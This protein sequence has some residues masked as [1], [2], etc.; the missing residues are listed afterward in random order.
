MASPH[1]NSAWNGDKQ[2]LS[3]GGSRDAKAPSHRIYPKQTLNPTTSQRKGSPNRSHS[4]PQ[5]QLSNLKHQWNVQ[6]DIPTGTVR[7]NPFV[8]KSEPTQTPQPPPQLLHQKKQ[9]DTSS[10][11]H[12]S[13]AARAS[14][15][16]ADV[17]P[18]SSPNPRM[19]PKMQQNRSK[20]ERH[21]SSPR[22][23]SS[24]GMS[25]ASSY[26][27]K[28]PNN[29]QVFTFD[30][31]PGN[32]T[33]SLRGRIIENP[34]LSD[35]SAPV[36]NTGGKWEPSKEIP[37]GAVKGRVNKFL[38]PAEPQAA[39]TKLGN[40]GTSVSRNKRQQKYE[41]D[42]AE[43]DPWI[44][45]NHSGSVKVEAENWGQALA[46]KS[47]ESDA[48]DTPDVDW[49]KSS[50]S[51]KTKTSLDNNA[52]TVEGKSM[53]AFEEKKFDDEEDSLKGRESNILLAQKQKKIQQAVDIFETAHEREN[54]ILEAAKKKHSSRKISDA[55]NVFES[56]ADPHPQSTA[57]ETHEEFN[58]FP[59]SPFGG[60][61]HFGDF[62][63][64]QFHTASDPVEQQN[65]PAKQSY[66]NLF[67]EQKRPAPTYNLPLHREPEL[68]VELV[69]SSDEPTKKDKKG[70]FGKL[71]G[72]R[73]G[74]KS[75]DSKQR[76]NLLQN[77][78]LA[79]TTN[80]EFIRVSPTGSPPTQLR[81]SPKKALPSLESPAMSSPG[82]PGSLDKREGNTTVSEMT[83]PTIFKGASMPIDA[84]IDVTRSEV[85]AIAD[86]RSPLVG[87]ATAMHMVRENDSKED[88]DI[89]SENEWKEEMDVEG[90]TSRPY[91]NHADYSQP[92]PPPPPPPH[93][94]DDMMFGPGNRVHNQ[95]GDSVNGSAFDAERLNRKVKEFKKKSSS[96]LASQSQG[97]TGKD[98]Y[99]MS[100]V[101]HH[102]GKS[103]N[104]TG[105]AKLSN[106]VMTKFPQAARAYRHVGKPQRIASGLPNQN[107][108][109]PRVYDVKSAL[110]Q[111]SGNS[112]SQRSNE[113]LSVESD[114]RVLRTILRRPRRGRDLRPVA[115][116]TQVFATYNDD[117]VM[118]PMQ[119][120]GLRLLSAA[121]IP[122]QTE[123]RRFLAMR[124]ALTRMWALI[125]IQAYVRR[126]VARKK[127]QDDVRAIVRV[128]ALARGNMERNEL[129]YRHIC[130]I[131]VQRHVRG[132]LA[133][134][135]VYEEIYKVTMVQSFV[136]MKLA[137]EEATNRMALVIQLQSV[138]RGFIVRQQLER[139]HAC[140][141]AIQANWR[142]FFTRLTYQFDL[143]DII[144]VQSV[145]RRK[146]A[147]KEA[148]SLRQQAEN[149]AAIAIQTKWR[150]YDASMNY[151]HF[152]ADVLICQSTSRRFLVLTRVKKQREAATRIQS[153][154]RGFVSYADYMFS[155]ADI[156]SV[157]KTAR[158]WL[159]LRKVR[160]IREDLKRKDAAL[161]IQKCWRGFVA[162]TEYVVMKYE[163]Y[164]A[165][166]IQTYWR[167]FWNFSN[168]VIALDCTI[169]IQRAYRAHCERMRIKRVNAA[170]KI[171][172]TY[173]VYTH[174]KL[175]STLKAAADKRAQ[176][177]C[178]SVLQIQ[179]YFRGMQARVAVKAYT[180]ARRI[181]SQVRGRQARTAVRFYFAARKI[182]AMWRCKQMYSAYKFYRA[183]IT[184]QAVW[185][186]KRLFS[187]YKGYR[188]ARMIQALWRGKRLYWRYKC[189]R[190]ACM[191]QAAWR[192]RRLYFA[193]KCYRSARTIQ[194]M[195]KGKRL[196]FAYKCYRSARMIQAMWRGKRMHSAYK[197][198]CC[199]RV[200][201]TRYRSMRARREAL[202]L[203]GEYLAASLIQSAW[204]GFVCYT[205]YIF[206]I[207]D[208]IAAQKVA[209][210]YLAQKMYSGVIKD[211]V[212]A[213]KHSNESAASLQ[214]M[215]RGF[216]VRQRYW[217]IL[218]CTMQ[219][220]S[221]MR[222]RIVNL[223]IRRETSARLRLQ[224]FGRRCL[225]RQ[226]FLQRKFILALLKTADQE[227]TK[228]VAVRVIQEKAR[229]YLDE[230]KRDDAA[231][232]IQRFFL[233]VKCEVDHMVRATKKRKSWRKKM[234]NSRND[235][236]EEALLEDAWRC[237]DHV[238]IAGLELLPQSSS[239]GSSG[240]N[241]NIRVNSLKSIPV[242]GSQLGK[243]KRDPFTDLKPKLPPSYD[244]KVSQLDDEKTEFSGLTMS[245]A[246]FSRLS[247]TRVKR[248]EP[249]EMDEDLE[250]E[251]AFMDYEISTRKDR[252]VTKT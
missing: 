182:Q 65:K 189:Y 190:S 63:E 109:N 178:N 127:Y 172:R 97:T 199:A 11:Q 224:C 250:L 8:P 95:S 114:I 191:I 141:T 205:D 212:S 4:P 73:K 179:A 44:I 120:A 184:I 27:R 100:Q 193:Y 220:Q 219:I 241:E 247:L 203:R 79:T 58:A 84:S 161:V 154:W 222:G 67:I 118:D 26:V 72:G 155:V 117:S 50:D 139:E 51:T 226:E 42:M 48:W 22:R 34:L 131:E 101:S 150:S 248:R 183:A 35:S 173:I 194:A 170:S 104:S 9:W 98:M 23:T 66:E 221:W 227:K 90:S 68:D 238:S 144:V 64:H 156:V 24:K 142:C 32:Q 185:R 112:R 43:D 207:S 217:Y 143:L 138:A 108:E 236:I 240:N 237:V 99:A 208:I 21:A 116:P 94:R 214:K 13:V 166:T 211:R 196:Y 87:G 55:F 18:K 231:R 148:R 69:D 46:S 164:A 159:S 121:V 1:V 187:A 15:M 243:I 213:K 110:S 89:V 232:V 83:V 39:P 119:R 242:L 103:K 149:R 215:C 61:N 49:V 85:N 60:K 10:I 229:G 134:M 225:A 38:A 20:F 135:R 140:A 181:Q 33:T 180:S 133:T 249:R 80:R 200:I 122:I 197:F 81:K 210:R 251:E 96:R 132:Y 228:R 174:W 106:S 54:D 223:R 125:V 230:R 204:R 244:M 102:A 167:R 74:R 56:R 169:Q 113:S 192:R 52:F 246:A 29:N 75:T 136:R 163:H 59:S 30:N 25:P 77:T 126:H 3:V 93:H 158:K 218:G 16:E 105:D 76:D 111:E 6:R 152:L 209:R 40:Y 171:Q 245:T 86:S 130:A 153:T 175:M 70:F 198:Y 88:S 37:V 162:E 235:K 137:M 129:I 216:I 82:S 201:Q 19:S 57:D 123:V 2:R 45:P 188:S 7:N 36:R 12:G 78:P 160:T 47:A 31:V 124:R 115:R 128:Q 233:M 252:R 28:S 195:W 71:F 206:T 91:D 202:V 53:A 157:Q 92:P 5:D 147:I 151:L 186:G 62:Q 165:R 168:Y 107:I 146:M 145:W 234:T 41:Q 239:H 17:A 14:S 177:E 176:L